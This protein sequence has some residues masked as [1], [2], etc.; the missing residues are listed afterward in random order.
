MFLLPCKRNK[1]PTATILFKILNNSVYISKSLLGTTVRP[2]KPVI[3][4][5]DSM[6]DL[7]AE[8]MKES[9][10]DIRFTPS[11]PTL[12]S[13]TIPTSTPNTMT[14]SSFVKLVEDKKHKL[15][16]PII[17]PLS[18]TKWATYPSM[19]VTEKARRSTGQSNEGTNLQ[20]NENII[21]SSN[22]GLETGSQIDKTE[23]L[24]PIL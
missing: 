19:T 2:S 22:S 7:R 1:T 8:S 10:L 14:L 17:R 9:R 6:K 23:D 4:V 18:Y 16:I 5:H 3:L 13:P 21:R 12:S 11:P 15:I 20:I 24:I